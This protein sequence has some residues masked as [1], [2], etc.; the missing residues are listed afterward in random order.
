MVGKELHLIIQVIE[1]Y[2]RAQLITGNFIERKGVFVVV[3]F[4]V[5]CA[6]AEVDLHC[7][8]VVLLEIE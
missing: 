2:A 7:D 3:A 8:Y 5:D 4:E 1:Q 6:V